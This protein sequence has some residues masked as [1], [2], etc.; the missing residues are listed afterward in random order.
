M[1]YAYVTVLSTND[2]LPG[3][4]VMF[5]SLKRTN[6]IYKEF[7]VIVNENISEDN[8]QILKNKGYKV[9]LRKQIKVSLNNNEDMQY[10]LNTFDK[11]HI[12]ELTAYDKII[13]LDSDMLITKNI[14]HLFEKPHLSGVIAGKEIYPEWDGINSGLMVIVPEEGITNKLINV[15]ETHNFNKDIGDQDVINYYYDWPNLNLALYEGYNIFA[16]FLE[17]YINKFNYNPNDIYIIHYIGKIKPWMFSYEE[18]INQL[19]SYKNNN[20]LNNYHYY[21]MYLD[22]LNSI[23]G[24]IK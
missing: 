22:I 19:N 7:V 17:D 1:K 20:E 3:V 24:D 12:F 14:D 6:P 8:I 2:Y 18:Q 4:L 5:E 11:L 23:K 21:K 13:Y 16:C 9:L 15:I 10:W